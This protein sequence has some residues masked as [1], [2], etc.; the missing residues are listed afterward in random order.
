MSLG[1]VARDVCP[2]CDGTAARTLYKEALSEGPLGKYLRDYYR[3][4]MP[5]GIFQLD[6]CLDCGLVFQRFIPNDQLLSAI[7][8]DWL[9][10]TAEDEPSYVADLEGFQASR[11]GHEL[12]VLAAFLNKPRL[13]VLDYGTGWGLWPVIAAKLGHDA[14]ATELA[15]HKA[16][17][18]SDRDVTILCDDDITDHQFDVINLE[19]TLE[20]VTEPR[21]LLRLL[22]PSLTGVLKIAVPNASRAD[23]IVRD[24]E[25]GDYST[26]APVHPLEHVNSFD[27]RS[28]GHLADSVGLI[29]VR[30]SLVQRFAFVTRG[31]PTR[32]IQFVK[33]FARPF[34]A[35]NSGTNLYRWFVRR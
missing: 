34:V 22:V 13:K 32:P 7:Y 2:A 29:E 27:S 6:R 17:W 11:D 20:H 3:Q 4:P 26:I 31:I 9:L 24:L 12:M 14:Y 15:E 16:K 1:F 33:E 8:S 25:R 30:P 18:V 21:E 5:D 19:Q 10:Q 23:S 35:F 28:L